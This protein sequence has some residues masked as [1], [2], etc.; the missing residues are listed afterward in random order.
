[1]GI[2]FTHKSALFNTKQILSSMTGITKNQHS[3]WVK[4]IGLG[5]SHLQKDLDGLKL[6]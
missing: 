3:D 2:V 4:E 1:M 5:F 6:D